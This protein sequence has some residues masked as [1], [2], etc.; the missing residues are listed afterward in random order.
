VAVA[1]AS[2]RTTGGV[3]TELSE[4][5]RHRLEGSAA[6]AQP[7]ARQNTSGY[8]LYLVSNERLRRFLVERPG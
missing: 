3:A 6:L 1:V 7:R 4:L 5:R 2:I 8:A